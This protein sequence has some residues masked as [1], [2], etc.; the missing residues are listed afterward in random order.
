MRTRRLAVTAVMAVLLALAAACS[1][2][3]PPRTTPNQVEKAALAQ[4]RQSAVQDGVPIAPDVWTQLWTPTQ[5]GRVIKAC[6]TRGSAGD[7]EFTADPLSQSPGQLT[8]GVHFS[9]SD[10]G[11]NNPLAS[12]RLVDSCVAAYP[13]DFRLALLPT[14]VSAALYSYDLTVLRRC[15]AAHGQ[16]VP[17]LPSRARFEHLLRAGAPWNAYDLVVVKNRAAWYALA[18]ACPALP[19]AIAK[20]VAAANTSVQGR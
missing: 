20:R 3:P 9:N 7:V 18:D 17:R 13:V 8:Y 6:V 1:A 2:A 5:A 15:L 19:A 14:Q 10:S 4:A 16:R 11:F 12:W